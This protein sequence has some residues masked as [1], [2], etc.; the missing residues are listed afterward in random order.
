MF[1]GPIRN[2]DDALSA[3]RERPPHELRVGM[4]WASDLYRSAVGD[5]RRAAELIDLDRD[6]WNRLCRPRRALAINFPVQ[7]DNGRTESFTGY[8]VQHILAMGPTKG[9]FRCT[10]LVSLGDCA[11]MAMTMTWKCAL[12]ELPFGGA[13]GG[14]RCDPYSLTPTELGRLTRRYTAE[15]LPMVGPDRDIPSPD[16]GTG[17]DEMALVMDTYSQH[18]GHSTPAVV[19]GKPVALGGLAARRTATGQGVVHVLEM[20]LERKGATLAEQRVA[21]QGFGEVGATIARELHS[22]GATVVGVSDVTGGLVDSRGLDITRVSDWVAD[23]GR[24]AGCPVGAPVDLQ[25]FLETPCDVLIPAALE[26]QI[27]AKGARR[28]R[29]SL[30]VE[31]GNGPTTPAG[32]KELARRGIEVVPDLVANGGGVAASYFEWVQNQQQYVWD[33]AEVEQRLA[34]RLRTTLTQVADR[35]LGLNVDWR[36]AAVAVAMERVATA[37]GIR[38]IYP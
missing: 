26:R 19:T 35:A 24:L 27:T 15:M 30:V 9:G 36:T 11:A 12:L 5:A 18:V 31:A 32:E 16:M 1:S 20:V 37:S 29:C 2:A 33:A 14:V 4:E 23:R 6:L 34:E 17:E 28:I 22:R 8:R 21:I 25:G 7:M 10:P 38:G 13:K 3:S